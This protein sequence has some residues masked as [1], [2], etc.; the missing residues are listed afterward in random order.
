MNHPSKLFI[1]LLFVALSCTLIFSAYE[2]MFDY[3]GSAPPLQ[4]EV[5]EQPQGQLLTDLIA[6]PYFLY[7]VSC[8]FAYVLTFYRPKLLL[9]SVFMLHMMVEVFR[10]FFFATPF[11]SGLY[12]D[13][14]Y[15][16]PVA[17][18]L[19][20]KH[21]IDVAWINTYDTMLFLKN[22]LGWEVEL[23]DVKEEKPFEPE[24]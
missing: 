1:G 9:Y 17:L 13:Y 16:T 8:A 22:Y 7:A 14:L 4:K 21:P 23:P 15:L 24:I 6:S 12:E 18:A 19:K 5:I 11:N 20:R 3:E 2:A 10:R